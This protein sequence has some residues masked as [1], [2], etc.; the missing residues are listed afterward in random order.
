VLIGWEL[1]EVRGTFDRD[2]VPTDLPRA[3]SR[4]YT[5]S[6][7]NRAS[8]RRDLESWRGRKFNPAELEG[9]DLRKL[10][11]AAALLQVVHETSKEGRTYAAVA[12]IMALPKGTPRPKGTENP[13]VFFSFEDHAGPGLPELPAGLP[14]WVTAI[15]CEA[16]EWRALAEPTPEWARDGGDVWEAPA[17]APAPSRPVPPPGPAP[18]TDEIPLPF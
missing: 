8:L 18:A 9:F 1:P 17:E 13:P 15:I 11:G 4:R 3:L 7:D 5:V 10:L 2:G 12:S 16:K 14:P 6:L